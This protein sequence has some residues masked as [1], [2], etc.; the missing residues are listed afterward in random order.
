MNLTFYYK[1]CKY[2]ILGFED[3]TSRSE[4]ALAKQDSYAI[5][6]IRR[7]LNHMLMKEKGSTFND[8][9][10]LMHYN[11]MKGYKRSS[12]PTPQDVNVEKKLIAIKRVSQYHITTSS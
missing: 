12:I 5:P 3:F 9:T 10:D 7:Q 8:F 4:I 2:I 11:A 6:I 1:M